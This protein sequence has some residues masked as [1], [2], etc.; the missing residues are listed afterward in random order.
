MCRSKSESGR[1][2]GCA[3]DPSE[4]SAMRKAYSAMRAASPGGIGQGGTT[5]NAPSEVW[6][7][8]RVTALA[9]D[10]SAAYDEQADG[11]QA[12]H[13]RLIDS[14]GSR[15]AALAAV[16]AAVAEEADRRAGVDPAQ[17]RADYTVH[18]ERMQDR[19]DQAR[20]EGASD[21]ELTDLAREMLSTLPE[22]TDRALT[23]LASAYREVLAEIRPLGGEVVVV[24]GSDAEAT[25]VVTEAMQTFPTGWVNRQSTAEPM[26]VQDGA[27]RPMYRDSISYTR[28]E[29]VPDATE[30]DSSTDVPE[31]GPEAEVV[32]RF[33][34]GGMT[35]EE[36]EK[37]WNDPSLS[38]TIRRRLHRSYYPRFLVRYETKTTKGRR[39][40]G[41][42]WEPWDGPGAP[43]E[44]TLWR[45]P[46]VTSQTVMESGPVLSMG[47]KERL[48]R[49]AAVHE[50]THRFEHTV[51][52]LVAAEREFYARR[53]ATEDGSPGALVNLVG[54]RS[55][56]EFRPDSFANAYMGKDYKG[57]FYE[58]TSVGAE[59]LFEKTSGGLIGGGQYAPDLDSR[60]FVLGV[61]SCID[62]TADTRQEGDDV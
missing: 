52:G 42:G 45:R 21:E 16:G 54:Y 26:F 34:G 2:C 46:K 19:Y 35:E 43:E 4:R 23:S 39:P 62:R 53:T 59:A 41:D 44:G 27:P 50:S 60:A 38:E 58:V 18:A 29:V 51:P 24:E 25:R 48:R 47:G 37:D 17:V 8:E 12:A 1:R 9:A 6:N 22:D 31:P 15:E 56:E 13:D 30:M 28:D 36:A 61:L 20:A 11:H 40:K 49:A 5:V 3:A 14:Y 10:V 55:D 33:R 32:V 7:V 57:A